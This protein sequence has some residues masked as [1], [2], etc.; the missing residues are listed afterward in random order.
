MSL[1]ADLRR[2]VQA[3]IADTQTP[4]AVALVGRGDEVLCHEAWG[5]R[6][7]SP[8]PL[9]MERDTIFDMASVTKPLAT[10]M[11]VM[12]LIERGLLLLRDPVCRYLPDFTGEGREQVTL[13][14]LLTHTAGLEPYKN[15]L[16][17]WG[18]EVLPAER[19]A[20][21]VADICALPVRHAPGE[22]FAYSCLG[23][24]LL[25]SIV[26]LVAGQ[27]LDVYAAEHTFSPLGM[28][29]TGFRLTAAQVARCAAT[30]QLAEGTLV[31]VVH[32]ENARYLGG[33]GG[34]AGLFST[35]P[36]VSRFARA[37]LA[38]IGSGPGAAAGGPELP[39]SPAAAARMVAP[40]AEVPGAVRALGWD[41]DSVYSPPMR[42]D[43]FPVGG[44]GHTGYTGTSLW[45]DPGS[46]GYVVLLTNRVHLGRD[47]DISRLRQQVANIAAAAVIGKR[48]QR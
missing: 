24:I 8:A 27:P 20:R 47:R 10:A 23:Y 46:G 33:V 25:T 43:L 7:L 37:L 45:I 15:Y 13:R 14:H 31:G 32:D 22:A 18:A 36:D 3:A 35:A 19:R 16:Q 39:L 28:T 12:Q 5:H 44:I 30:E 26:E 17:E 40:G 48:G 41:I 21:M 42:G 29:D 34:N 2:A 4:G 38:R 11:A 6:T 1:T 9:P